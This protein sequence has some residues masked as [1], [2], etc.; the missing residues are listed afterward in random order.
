MRSY[1]AERAPEPE[2][3]PSIHPKTRATILAAVRT[4]GP[5]HAPAVAQRTGYT[6][7]TVWRVLTQMEREGAVT[8][9]TDE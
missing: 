9:S 6:L 4:G 2:C 7:D 5:I 8:V 3:V 1:R